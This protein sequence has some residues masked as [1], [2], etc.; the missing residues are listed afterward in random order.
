MRMS[1]AGSTPPIICR[2]GE[3]VKLRLEGVP[4]GLLEDREYDEVA[5]EARSGDV[6]LLHSDGFDDQ[7]IRRARSSD[8]GASSGH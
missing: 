4:L 6:I 2:D 1:N 8:P 3:Q 5:F 7:S